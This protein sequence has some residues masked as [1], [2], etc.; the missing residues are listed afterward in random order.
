MDKIYVDLDNDS[1]NFEEDFKPFLDDEVKN[2]SIQTKTVWHDDDLSPY[3]LMETDSEASTAPTQ[4]KTV[5]KAEA[6]SPYDVTEEDGFDQ[7]KKRI[8]DYGQQQFWQA[9]D[10][11]PYDLLDTP[12]SMYFD[13]SVDEMENEDEFCQGCENY[14]T[15]RKRQHPMNSK[16]PME[17]ASQENF[18]QASMSDEYDCIHEAD[19]YEN[20][21]IDWQ[22]GF[23]VSH[24]K[25]SSD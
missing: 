24:T 10:Q 2:P 25:N 3:D 9:E 16:P 1:M 14:D 8:H 12:E 5:W 4:A 6:Q 19:M 17:E 20:G 23:D 22:C 13:D 21:N 18:N 15:C 11:S 7:V